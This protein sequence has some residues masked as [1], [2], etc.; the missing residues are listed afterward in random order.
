MKQIP[1]RVCFLKDSLRQSV[2]ANIVRPQLSETGYYG[3]VFC[4]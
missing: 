4:H 3:S 2:G 1:S